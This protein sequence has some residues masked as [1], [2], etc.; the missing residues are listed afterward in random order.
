M[1]K[2]QLQRRLK[3]F[4][5][6]VLL[7]FAVNAWAEDKDKT[8]PPE[9]SAETVEKKLTLDQALMCENMKELEPGNKSVIFSVS[10]AHAVCFTSFDPV[11]EKCDIFHNW[12][13]RDQPDASFKLTLKPP[14]WSS[15]SRVRLQSSDVGPW[16]V[17]ITDANGKILKTL[18][19]SV[20]E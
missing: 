6:I 19:F 17:E 11:P 5:G 10:I 20:T 4:S 1:N 16:R 9:I 18:Y 14:K 13:Q 2:K 12:F 3:I 15:F 8:V 7:A